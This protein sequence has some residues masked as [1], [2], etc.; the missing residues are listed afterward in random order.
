[1]SVNKHP[2]KPGHWQIRYYPDGRKGKQKDIVIK[3]SE[4][5]ALEFEAQFRS[6]T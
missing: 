1:M 3:G 6:E 2:T 4:V 5:Q